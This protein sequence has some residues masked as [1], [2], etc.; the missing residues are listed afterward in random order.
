MEFPIGVV[1]AVHRVA[2]FEPARI[3][4]CY[5][6]LTP[7]CGLDGYDMAESVS[8]KILPK[9]KEHS[10]RGFEC[11]NAHSLSPRRRVH[12][13]CTHIRPNVNHSIP[14]H[15]LAISRRVTLLHPDI[16]E[17]LNERLT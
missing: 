3:E 13:K 9:A 1:S 2:S 8:G 7:A 15:D 14:W 6:A 16:L 4:I 10:R 17:H 12:R 11:Y 5:S